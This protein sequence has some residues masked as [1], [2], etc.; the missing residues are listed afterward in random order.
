MWIATILWKVSIWLETGKTSHLDILPTMQ[1]PGAP[2]EKSHCHHSRLVLTI[3]IERETVVT[4]LHPV[5][6]QSGLDI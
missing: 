2:S 3:V 1:Y 5:I 4:S 6:L